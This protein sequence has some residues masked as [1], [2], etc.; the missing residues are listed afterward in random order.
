MGI[1]VYLKMN[2]YKLESKRTVI[3]INRD[4]RIRC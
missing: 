2:Y 4:Q 1:F 3:D